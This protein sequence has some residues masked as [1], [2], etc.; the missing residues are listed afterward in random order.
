MVWGDWLFQYD[1]WATGGEGARDYLWHGDDLQYP[2]YN[3]S[4]GFWVHVY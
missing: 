4:Y 2:Y 1:G 3:S